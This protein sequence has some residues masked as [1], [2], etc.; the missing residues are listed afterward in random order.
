MDFVVLCIISDEQNCKEYRHL[1]GDVEA[2]MASYMHYDGN[3]GSYL[4]NVK[5]SDDFT[6]FSEN[7]CL[8]NGISNAYITIFLST[9][10]FV[11]K[12]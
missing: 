10:D 2:L 4:E 3:M 5:Y 11:C 12:S 1:S 8:N 7:S 9:V 6:V